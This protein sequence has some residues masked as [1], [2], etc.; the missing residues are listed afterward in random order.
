MRPFS[1]KPSTKES[2]LAGSAILLPKLPSPAPD[3][4]TATALTASAGTEAAVTIFDSVGIG[5]G[6]SPPPPH[7]PRPRTKTYPASR[8]VLRKPVIAPPKDALS[9]QQRPAASSQCRRAGNCTREDLLAPLLT[10]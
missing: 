2:N 9:V 8:I 1:S 7:E 10:R 3:A 4:T 6:L 5:A